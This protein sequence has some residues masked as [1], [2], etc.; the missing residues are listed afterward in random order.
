MSKRKQENVFKNISLGNHSLVLAR[1]GK[2]TEGIQKSELRL[3][4][5]T[6]TEKYTNGTMKKTGTGRGTST[7]CSN[8]VRILIGTKKAKKRATGEGPPPVDEKE[9]KRD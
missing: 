1:D 5:K 9:K 8:R 6:P 7:A 3:K 2:R 4:I